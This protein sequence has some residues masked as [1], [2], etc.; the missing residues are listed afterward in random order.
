MNLTIID[1]K[2]L[3]LQ[4]IATKEFGLSYKPKMVIKH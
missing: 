2:S 4:T 1:T 3:V